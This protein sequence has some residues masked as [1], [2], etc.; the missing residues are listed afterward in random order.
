MTFSTLAVIM[1]IA[2][3]GPLLATPKRS[4]IPMLVGELVAGVVVGKTGGRVLHPTNTT[5]TFLADIGFA[6]IMF[7][8]GSHVP[9]RDPAVRRSLRAGAVRAAGVVAIAVGLGVAIASAFGTKHEALYAVLVASSSAALALPLLDGVGVKPADALDTVAQI[10]VADTL[11]IVA[12]PLAI[13][14]SRAAR[15]ALGALAV[16]VAAVAVFV[17]FDRGER[18][19]LRRRVHMLS[20]ER[21]FALEL[22]ISLL[23]LC[24]L[25]ALATRSHVSIML[26]GFSFGLVI[27]AVGE[28]R[29][30]AR[31]VFGLTEGFFGPLFFVWIGASLD[32][33]ALGHHPKFLLLGVSLGAAAVAA[34]ALMAFARQRPPL[35]VVSS[36]QL[37]VPI[38]AVTLG[39]Q[40]H[41][42]QPGEPGALLLGALLTIAAASFAATRAATSVGAAEAGPETAG[43][44]QMNAPVQ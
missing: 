37:G 38:A 7:V 13:E 21:N 41:L 33:R 30:L 35:A 16:A 40:R 1:A 36:A 43:G 22:R 19:G 4:P 11:C 24:A 15:A 18:S 25:A 6:L 2:L 44:H 28:P 23:A 39:T 9:V 20:E 31:Q 12:L 5:F 27:A 3:L 29:R 42:L 17:A 14:P 8:A 10:A 34:H 32:L 26:A